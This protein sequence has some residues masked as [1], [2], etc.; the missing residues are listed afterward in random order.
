M[1]ENVP[2]RDGT[3][4]AAPRAHPLLVL[5]RLAAELLSSSM[6]ALGLVLVLMAALLA[7]VMR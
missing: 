2:A 5:R 6:S 1:A 7:V 4:L 3:T